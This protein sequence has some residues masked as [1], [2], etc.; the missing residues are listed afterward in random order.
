MLN[1][2]PQS[3]RG[4][5]RLIKARL[6]GGLGRVDALVR[7][8]KGGQRTKLA[9]TWAGGPQIIAVRLEPMVVP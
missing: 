1:L 9:V 8:A 3:L 7:P 5:N 2:V 4:I 6:A